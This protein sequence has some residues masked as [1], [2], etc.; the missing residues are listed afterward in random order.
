[1]RRKFELAILTLISMFIVCIKLYCQSSV[2]EH[3][4]L[5]HGQGSDKRLFKNIHFDSTRFVVHYITLPIPERNDDM[6]SYA[7]KV[8]VQIDT[9]TKFSIIGVSL[10]G[11]VATEMS[12]FLKP[13][14]TIIISSAGCRNELPYKYTF[15]K[16]IPIYRLI[17]AIVYKKGA[18]VAQPIVEPDRNKE[19][20]VCIMMLKDKNPIFLKRTTHL[21]V[22]WSRRTKPDNNFFHIHGTSDNT[23]PYRRKNRY[24]VAIPNGSHMMVLTQSEAIQKAINTILE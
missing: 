16:Y 20:A 9:N 1:M 22:N 19:K 5:I 21:I 23:L 24:D 4:Y 6:N 10:G 7:K 12:T 14:K 2:N 17:P 8:S 13:R 18:F 15:M 11:M 3:L